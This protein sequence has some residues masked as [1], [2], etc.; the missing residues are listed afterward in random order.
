MLLKA[1]ANA[2]D[3]VAASE[4]FS[5]MQSDGITP[6]EKGFGKL[7][8]AAVKSLAIASAELV[9][10]KATDV[11]GPNSWKWNMLI[12]VYAKHGFFDEALRG[13]FEMKASRVL[14]D[15]ITYSTL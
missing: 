14:P 9:F 7:L 15:A 3:F 4:F 8:E 5:K 13:F 12:D 1:M 2:G 6:N 10:K 11:F